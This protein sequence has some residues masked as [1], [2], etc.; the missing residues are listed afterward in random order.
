MAIA[1][2]PNIKLKVENLRLL[3]RIKELEQK[4]EK[5]SNEMKKVH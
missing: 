2:K 3:E 4:Q 1:S 5:E